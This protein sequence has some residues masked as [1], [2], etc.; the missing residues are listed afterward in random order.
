MA[1]TLTGALP[2]SGSTL[3]RHSGETMAKCRQSRDG[4]ATATLA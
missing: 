3:R 2:T 4:R 1:Q